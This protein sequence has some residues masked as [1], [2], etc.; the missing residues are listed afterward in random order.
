M[1]DVK[2][3]INSIVTKLANS[4]SVENETQESTDFNS[5]VFKDE[6]IL[7]SA[8]QLSSYIP[9]EI[10]DMR[11]MIANQNYNDSY[12]YNFYRQGKSMENYEDDCEYNGYFLRYYPTYQSMDVKQL[13]GY[14]TWR[15]QT[16]KGNIKKTALSFIYVYIYELLN[17]IGV[18]TAEE[19]FERLNAFRQEY[20]KI[21]PSINRNA[22]KWL[23]DYIVYNNLSKELFSELDETDFDNALLTFLNANERDNK[24]LFNAVKEL[25][26]YNIEKSKFYLNNIEDTE[27]AVCKIIRTLIVYYGTH[28]SKSFCE[29][30]FGHKISCAYDMFNSAVFYDTKKYES[31]TYKINDINIFECRHGLW[32]CDRY[33]LGRDKNKTLGTIIRA[34]DGI[35]REKCNFSSKLSYEVKEKTIVKIITNEVDKFLEE[36]HKNA[37][38]KIEID[39]TKLES[40]RANADITR[41]KLIVDEEE[42]EPEAIQENN[43]NEK[44]I[45]TTPLDDN[46]YEFMKCLLYEKQYTEFLS[47]KRLMPS[48]IADSVN[49]KLYEMFGDTVIVFDGDVPTLIEDY[50]EE[51]KGIIQ[52]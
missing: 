50:I 13:R 42:D 2:E 25:S 1:A 39:I 14:F 9:Q 23:Q 17:Q 29:R 41:E 19:G 27:N 32:T 30:L 46:E 4:K 26:S 36:K 51:L 5:V 20:A 45:N 35:M 12:E 21:E 22:K 37:L 48:V 16:R 15:T 6:P 44:I 33:P 49:E 3:L 10:R 40:I 8:S 7:C 28:G 31:F 43:F 38:P 47:E 18:K 52:E 24:E 34:I 11:K